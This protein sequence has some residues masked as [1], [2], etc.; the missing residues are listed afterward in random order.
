M[1]LPLSIEFTKNSNIFLDREDREKRKENWENNLRQPDIIRNKNL[2]LYFSSKIFENRGLISQS[3]HNDSNKVYKVKDLFDEIQE[4]LI[5]FF[6][7]SQKEFY[8]FQFCKKHFTLEVVEIKFS[9]YIIPKF[10]AIDCLRLNDGD[11]LK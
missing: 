2:K 4:F 3:T 8:D 9:E 6:I 1:R 11:I 10:L 7:E 5:K